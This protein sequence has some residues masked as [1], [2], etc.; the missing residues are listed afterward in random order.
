M[1]EGYWDPKRQRWIAYEELSEEADRELDEFLEA[2]VSLP[3]PPAGLPKR[4][5]ATLL[6]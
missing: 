4:R 3:P 5:P 2:K 6:R 1:C